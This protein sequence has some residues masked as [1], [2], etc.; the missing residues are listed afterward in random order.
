MVCYKLS[1]LSESQ[2]EPIT[3]SYTETE[4]KTTEV[5]EYLNL[6]HLNCLLL[7]LASCFQDEPGLL[8]S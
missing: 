6:K 7:P 1:L 2:A 3:K 4:E 8:A 5:K